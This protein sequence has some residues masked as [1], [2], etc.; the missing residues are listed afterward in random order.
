[1]E[2]LTLTDYP[3]LSEDDLYLLTLT[4]L[5]LDAVANKEAN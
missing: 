5:Q 3:T 4:D 1:M 2:A